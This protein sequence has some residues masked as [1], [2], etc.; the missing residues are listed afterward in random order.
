MHKEK[1]HYKTVVMSD[2]HLGSKHCHPNEAADFLKHSTCE[3]LYLNGDILDGWALKR[4]WRWKESYNDV[5]K[6]IL[7]KSKQGTKVFYITGNHDEFLRPI[8][9][10]SVNF[11]GIT[12]CNEVE[13]ICV[14][15]H[16]YIVTHGDLF[17][18]ITRV[19]PWLSKFGS[20]GYDVLIECN[21]A[22]NIARHKIGLKHWSFSKFVKKNIK[23]A[24]NHL[25][26]FESCLSEYCKSK[27]YAGIIVGH[28]HSPEIKSINGIDYLNSGDFVE[29][30][31]VLGI[32]ETWNVRK[33][34]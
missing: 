6:Q 13:H 33:S 8:I 31:T 3:F 12:I 23:R 15:G 10:D 32:K 2:L 24:A 4:K 29:S 22:L 5:I 14:D 7:K 25:V 18:G 20:I 21:S 11:G 34:G 16:S 17:D 1:T 26:K 19:A 9:K 28:V 30:C 27:G